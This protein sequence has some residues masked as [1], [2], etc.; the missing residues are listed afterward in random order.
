MISQSIKGIYRDVLC[1]RDGS[2]RFDS[3]WK[4]NT[5]VQGCHI[6]LAGFMNGSNH[7]EGIQFLAVGMGEPAWDNLA[8]IPATP[9][10]ATNL[11]ARAA[12]MIPLEQ[13]TLAY[14]DASGDPTTTPTP[15][16]Q[17]VT[18]LAE[19]FPT[20]PNGQATYPLR[21]FGLF[22]RFDGVDYMINCIRHRVIHKDTASTLVRTIQLTF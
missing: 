5:I 8:T 4:S 9:P 6:L 20:P 15:R 13:M 7:A 17:I 2:V 12:D 22:G 19:D 11:V 16:L 10:D 21:E 1:N 14:L 3:G 18:T